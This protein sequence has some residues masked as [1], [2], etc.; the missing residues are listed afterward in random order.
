MGQAQARR[1][2]LPQAAGIR[3]EE[4]QSPACHQRAFEGATLGLID[5]FAPLATRPIHQEA[6]R[7]KERQPPPHEYH[8][9]DGRRQ[10]DRDAAVAVAS[11]PIGLS[12]S[13]PDG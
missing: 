8:E 7:R 9:C 3:K 1:Q 13:D 6:H 4:L 11:E 5:E 2:P 12:N 10:F